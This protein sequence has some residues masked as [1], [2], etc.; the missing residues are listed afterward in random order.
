M[1]IGIK[2][3]KFKNL[4]VAIYIEE[5]TYFSKDKPGNSLLYYCVIVNI[6]EQTYVLKKIGVVR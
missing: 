6:D 4:L 3:R 5:Q 1:K 2:N